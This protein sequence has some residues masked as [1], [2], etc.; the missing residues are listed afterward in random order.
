ME[1]QNP[2]EGSPLQFQIEVE[3][4]QNAT[5]DI[6]CMCYFYENQN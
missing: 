3:Y 1:I 2:F 6:A 4:F 5:Y